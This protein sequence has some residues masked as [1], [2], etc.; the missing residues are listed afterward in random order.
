MLRAARGGEVGL[1]YP[2]P[3]RKARSGPAICAFGENSSAGSLPS[4]RLLGYSAWSTL[5][6]LRQAWVSAGA[7]RSCRTVVR[8]GRFRYGR[9]TGRR[10]VTRRA[11]VVNQVR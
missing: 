1:N 4:E 3:V 2:N 10:A 8:D 5:I 9:Q 6:P 7:L 11:S